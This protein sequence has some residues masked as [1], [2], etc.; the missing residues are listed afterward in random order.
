MR[1]TL[2]IT[3]IARYLWNSSNIRLTDDG[4]LSSFQGRSSGASS[5]YASLLQ[6]IDGEM[7]LALCPQAVSCSSKL[8][9]FRDAS[10]LWW[11][12]F[13]PVYLLGH[14]PSLRHVQGGISTGDLAEKKG[15][16]DSTFHSRILNLYAPGNGFCTWMHQC[17]C[18][19]T[20]IFADGSIC[21]ESLWDSTAN[22]LPMGSNY[23]LETPPPTPLRPPFS[24]L[25]LKLWFM[26]IVGWFFH[27]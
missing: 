21:H 17:W 6:V 15:E 3:H 23:C 13:P 11:L 1:S 18:L 12:L 7:S 20:S 27:P 22:L 10:K 19:C 5:F 9:I 8:Q 4:P 2:S 24:V 16:K 14:F 25:F 26:G